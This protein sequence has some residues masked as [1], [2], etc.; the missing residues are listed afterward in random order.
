MAMSKVNKNQLIENTQK[1]FDMLEIDLKKG[2]YNKAELAKN[3]NYFL[4]E[5]TIQM[6][7]VNM[8]SEEKR[9][10]MKYRSSRILEIINYIDSYNDDY[11][12]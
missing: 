10:L 2:E 7:K 8:N 3:I 9:K 6:S 11:G 4:Y 1:G 5:N 12:F